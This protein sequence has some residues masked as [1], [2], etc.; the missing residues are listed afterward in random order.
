MRLTFFLY[1]W[2][3]LLPK[4]DVLSEIQ[5]IYAAHIEKKNWPFKK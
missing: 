3:V 4:I 5:I 2:A 1:K